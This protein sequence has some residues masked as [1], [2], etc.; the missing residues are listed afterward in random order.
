MVNSRWV[1]EES[2]GILKGISCVTVRLRLNRKDKRQIVLE[3]ELIPLINYRLYAHISYEQ[4]Q[5][6]QIITKAFYL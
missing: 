2:D 5:V 3:N 1:K 4:V 6:F